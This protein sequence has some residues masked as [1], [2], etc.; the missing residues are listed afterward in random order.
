VEVPE[1]DYSSF[2]RLV[3]HPDMLA[4]HR[5]RSYR[6]GLL[7]LLRAAVSRGQ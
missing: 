5:M 3:L 1:G 7:E 6:T 2:E 4:D